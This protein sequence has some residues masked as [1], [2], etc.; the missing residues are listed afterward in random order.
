MHFKPRTLI[1]S[2]I[3]V[4]CVV[5]LVLVW[6]VG[7]PVPDYV[8]I[9]DG[10]PSRV[11]TIQVAPYT[12][13]DVGM[14]SAERLVRSDYETYYSFEKASIAKTSTQ[15]KADLIDGQKSVFGR[16]G[17]FV[18]RIFDECTIRVDSEI[19]MTQPLN[20]FIT[21]DTYRVDGYFN[22][23][24]PSKQ[25][26]P[27]TTDPDSDYLVPFGNGIYGAY[28]HSYSYDSTTQ[29]LLY[30]DDKAGFYR[31]N[32]VYGVQYD[33]INQ[34]L[35]K[36]R[37]CYGL[38]LT[39]YWAGEDFV[40]FQSGDWTLGVRFIN[41]NTQRVVVCNDSANTAAALQTIIVG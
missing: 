38:T 29:T 33:V 15:L 26:L 27:A 12:F 6:F 4:L 19:S 11:Y 32:T 13:F 5:G 10:M 40:L 24:V 34:L 36:A 41:R 9:D 25:K 23:L 35:A 7:F 14:S 31:V 37:A 39:E 2:V 28:L 17:S 18:Y 21:G 22:D 16:P 30:L 1:W 8:A 20:A 3:A